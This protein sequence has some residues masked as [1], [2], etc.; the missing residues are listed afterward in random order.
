MAAT[1]G[2]GVVLV[3]DDVAAGPVAKLIHRIT[4]WFRVDS[5]LLLGGPVRFKFRYR[6]GVAGRFPG[7]SFDRA[8]CLTGKEGPVLIRRYWAG[9]GAAGGFSGCAMGCAESGCFGENVVGFRVDS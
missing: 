3:G 6:S 4:A 5:A 1:R 7:F 2:E 8:G 9:V